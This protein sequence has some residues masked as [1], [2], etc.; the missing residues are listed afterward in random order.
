MDTLPDSVSAVVIGAG[1]AGLAGAHELVRRGLVPGTD[2]LVLDGDDGPGGAW[3]HRWESLTLGAAHGI[4]DLPGM[5]MDRP[6]PSVPAAT[7][8][9]DYYGA[10]EERFGLSVVRPTRVVSVRSAG[11]HALDLTLLHRG[12][13]TTLRTRLL[14]NATGTWTHPYIPYVPGIADFAGRQLH[15]VDY[16]RKEDFAGQR[17][18]VV[19]G[20]LSAVQFLL[21]LNRPGSAARTVWATRRPPNFT[22]DEF[23]QRWGYG[24]EERVRAATTRG[25]RPESVVRNTGIPP[26][27]DYLAAVDSGVLV[28]RGMFGRLTG[29]GAVWAEQSARARED[30][31]NGLTRPDSWSPFPPGHAE[32]IDTVFW[33]TGFRPALDHLAPLH[34]REPG[35]GILMADEVRVAKDPRVL[36]LGYGSTAST[37]GANRSG[38]LAGRAAADLILR[39]DGPGAATP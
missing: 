14:L 27:A 34:L 19:G 4:A 18:L 20:G 22:P 25:R 35:G 33:N 7:L 2:F 15:T 21:E 5:P 32:D 16:V 28:S 24:V 1:Q 8:V 29:H 26:R 3:R 39:D 17:V 30:S 9:A 36:L 38:R 13:C 10:Y 37:V 12:T 6:D 23:D 31:D 11:E